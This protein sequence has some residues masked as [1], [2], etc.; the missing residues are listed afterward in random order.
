MDSLKREDILSHFCPSVCSSDIDEC[1]NGFVECDSRAT[2]VNLP[3]WY[4]CECR[5]GYHDNGMFLSNGESCEG[6]MTWTILWIFQDIF[7]LKFRHNPDSD[8]HP[9]SC[10][11]C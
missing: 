5:D 2:C 3:G 7:V 10:F 6:R 4:H 11:L 8:Y 9:F 1:S